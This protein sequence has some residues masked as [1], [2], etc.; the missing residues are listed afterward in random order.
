[1][2]LKIYNTLSGK[3]EPFTPREPGRVGMY[4]C[5]VTVYDHCHLGHA[6]GAVI[7][8]IIRRY[9]QYRG[10]KVTYVRN[11]TDVDD[12][13]IKK[14]LEQGV[15][16]G[17][18]ASHFIEEY[19]RDMGELRVRPADIEPRATEHVEGM[20]KL[21]QGLAER[22]YAYEAGGDVYFDVSRFE[23]YGALSHRRPE[24]LLA[25]YRVEPSEWKRNPLDFALWK[26]SK[27]GE[28]SWP[29]PWGEG[30]P[31]WHI[32]CSTMSMAYLGPSFDIHGGGEDLIFPHHENEIA[33]SVA[34][35]G[36]PFVAYWI[37]N[38]FVNVD[39]KK[40]SKSLGNFFTVREVL[41]RYHPELIRYFLLLTHY[42]SPIEFS[43][44]LVDEA[45]KGLD[46]LYNT[47][48]RLSEALGAA[49]IG[50]SGGASQEG[51]LSGEAKRAEELFREAMDDDF[52]TASAFGHIFDFARNVKA[53]MDSSPR[54]MGPELQAAREF[55]GRV[56]EVFGL[57]GEDPREWVQ[58]GLGSAR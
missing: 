7:F 3:K 6:R 44:A 58:K 16:S 11:F 39:Q 49:G 50:E 30:R 22:G 40:M 51:E 29:S 35:T 54:G 32:E 33:Q 26:S 46:R 12:K 47:L 38:G 42:R 24:E 53:F 31:G 43:D 55:F 48:A 23:D 27:P 18:I 17:E 56:G 52:N 9:L 21:I 41:G 36:K 57:F 37:H 45:R 28:P 2:A 8:D 20:V 25:G 13:I 10:F 34:Y 1:M 19:Y 4:V 15:P 5:G 14:S